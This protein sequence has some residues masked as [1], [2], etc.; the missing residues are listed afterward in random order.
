MPRMRL[1]PKASFGLLVSIALAFLSAS[2][3][4][5][6]LYAVYQREWGFSSITTTV[7]FAAY[8]IAVLAALL[9]VGRVSDHIGRRPMLFTALALQIIAMVVFTS[10]GSVGALLAARIVQGIATGS[11]VGAIGAG[12]LDLDRARGALA[13]SFAP[14]LGTS[15]GALISGLVVQYLSW[16]THLI[17]V[18]LICVFVVQG[19]VLTLMPETVTPK[20]G[21]LASLKPDIK[22][23]RPARGPFIVAAPVIF[24]VWALAGFYGALAPALTGILVRSHNAVYGG[25][26]L[27]TLAGAGAIAVLLVRTIQARS[28][29]LI[30]IPALV[31]GVAVTL[32]SIGDGGGGTASVTGF[33]V[34]TA[35]AGVGFGAGFLVGIRLVVPVVE[36]HERA[37]VL[38]LLY[39]VTYLGMGIPA[40][41]G[42]VLVVHGGGLIDTAREYGIAVIVL[43]LLALAALLVNGR[44]LQPTGPQGVVTNPSARS[45]AEVKSSRTPVAATIERQGGN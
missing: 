45:A 12:M 44:R 8:A 7:V 4:P 43:A 25:L 16:P 10:A 29:L 3:A 40:V 35:L 41:I 11:A 33:F 18:A 9:V 38:S 39:V 15:L 28:V 14:V 22:L 34:G 24:A 31:V 17:Y 23:P 27:F 20:P 30:G 37:G 32:V 5:T 26:G 2:T 36:A 21:A 42:G 13:N 6:P 1:G 19:L